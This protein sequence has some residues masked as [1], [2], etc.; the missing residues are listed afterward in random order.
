MSEE[1]KVVELK[2]DELEKVSGGG[3]SIPTTIEYKYS[4]GQKM[5]DTKDNWIYTI[6]GYDG[7]NA[8][9]NCPKYECRIEFI[10]E[11]SS[12]NWSVGETIARPESVLS[13]YN[14]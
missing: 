12:R 5:I 1:K 4:I 2:E 9:K 13:P 8:V 3:V 7:W 14:E 6:T 11:N 10:P